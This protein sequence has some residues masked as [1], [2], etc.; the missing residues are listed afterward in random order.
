MRNYHSSKDKRNAKVYCRK[1]K[2]KNLDFYL[3]V[4]GETVYLFTTRFFVQDIYEEYYNGKML[5]AVF[6]K[7]ANSR[8]QKLNERIIRMAK[9]IQQENALCLFD[10]SNHHTKRRRLQR[11]VEHNTRDYDEY[12]VA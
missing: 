7:T 8:Q 9:Y 10:K 5:N 3:E 2:N 6:K 1:G 11:T 12:E 4:K